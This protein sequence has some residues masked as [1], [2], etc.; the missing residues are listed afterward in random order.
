ME[1]NSIFDVVVTIGFGVIF[2]ILGVAFFRITEYVKSD[3]PKILTFFC[4]ILSIALIVYAI[5]MG[6]KQ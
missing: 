4:L 6:G 3:G 5:Y 1:I 2:I